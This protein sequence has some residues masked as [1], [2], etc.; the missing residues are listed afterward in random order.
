[1]A[2]SSNLP[3]SKRDGQVTLFDNSTLTLVADFNV[4]DFNFEL[5]KPEMLIIRDRGTIRSTRYTDDATIAL[6]FSVYLRALSDSAADAILDFIGK[7]AAA[8]TLAGVTAQSTGSSLFEPFLLDCKYRIDASAL[9]DNTY[10]AVFRKVHFTASVAE[11]DP[12]TIAFSGVCLGGVEL[13]K[14]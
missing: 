6:S 4:G 13:S 2:Y 11:G 9:G 14:V 3:K 12:D 10:D 1:M 7:A 5:S 8:G